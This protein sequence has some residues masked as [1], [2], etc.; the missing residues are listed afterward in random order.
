MGL[1]GRVTL[2]NRM[3]IGVQ[4]K[5]FNA[6]VLLCAAYYA[7]AAVLSLGAMQLDMHP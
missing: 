2:R 3:A 6:F 4:T 1:Q 5:V 7:A